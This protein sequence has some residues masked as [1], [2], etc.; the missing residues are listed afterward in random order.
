MKKV[1]VSIMII[2][3]VLVVGTLAVTVTGAGKYFGL[4][5]QEKVDLH[6]KLLKNRD[7]KLKDFEALDKKGAETQDYNTIVAAQKAGRDFKNAAVEEADAKTE[8]DA[9]DYDEQMNQLVSAA[10]LEIPGNRDAFTDAYKKIFDEHM[11]NV[12]ALCNKYKKLKESKQL[13]AKEAFT[14][15]QAEM[16]NLM[17][18]LQQNQQNVQLQK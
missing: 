3:A 12:K 7:Q 14:Q 15:L 6:D 16:N 13:T 18:K 11:K 1:L 4:S 8:V 2:V 17:D 10:T 5:K 9:I